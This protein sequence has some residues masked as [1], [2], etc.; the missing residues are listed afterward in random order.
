MAPS[1]RSISVQLGAVSESYRQPAGPAWDDE[2]AVEEPPHTRHSSGV[3]PAMRAPA[4]PGRAGGEPG[5]PRSYWS[6]LADAFVEEVNIRPRQLAAR[7]LSRVLPQFSFIRTRTALLRALGLRIGERS[8]ILGALEVTGLGDPAELLSIGD[9]T[10][11]TGPLHVDL[12]GAAVRIGSRVRMGHHVS[13][14]TMDHEIGP[15]DNRCGRLVTAPITIGDGVWLGSSVTVLGGITI[16]KG[17]IVC[18][19]AVV[20]RDVPPDTLV[21]GVPAKFLRNLDDAAPMSE[22]RHHAFLHEERHLA[23]SGSGFPVDSAHHSGVRQTAVASAAAH[24]AT[25]NAGG[26][27]SAVPTPGRR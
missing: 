19:G 6:R 21:G 2:S 26:P 25:A 7:T 27:S 23:W 20:T 1:P 18:A 15:S 8:L 4:N 10:F 11:I 9:D 24:A 17:S 22:R 14:L 5:A 16:G 13:L 3:V 12:G